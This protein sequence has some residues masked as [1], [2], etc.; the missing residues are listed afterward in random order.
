ME[1]W[2]GDFD[3]SCYGSNVGPMGYV[4]PNLDTAQITLT[5]R[6]YKE[7]LKAEDRL[8]EIERALTF[9]R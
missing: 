7:L 4:A 1:G 9:S 8:K 5:E 6:R 2:G 3:S